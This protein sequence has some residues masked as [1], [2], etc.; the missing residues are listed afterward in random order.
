MVFSH[1][2]ASNAPVWKIGRGNLDYGVIHCCCSAL[3]P[4]NELS[5]HLSVAGENIDGKGL[6]ILFNNSVNLLKILI[7]N[8]RQQRS[9]KLLVHYRITRPDVFNNRRF[10]VASVWVTFTS[11]DNHPA[12]HQ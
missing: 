8:D 9:E 11:C 1:P 3:C 6:G 5:C 10:N 12:V 7:V 4:G 2:A